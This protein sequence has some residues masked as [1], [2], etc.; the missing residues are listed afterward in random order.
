VTRKF[1]KAG[2]GG[3]TLWT[4]TGAINGVVTAI[5]AVQLS[6]TSG[7]INKMNYQLVG[8]RFG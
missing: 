2:G 4:S 7:N 6:F 8:I 1:I 5:N 3:W